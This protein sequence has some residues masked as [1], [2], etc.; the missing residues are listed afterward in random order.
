MS[1]DRRL[2]KILRMLSHDQISKETAGA[3][4]DALWTGRRHQRHDRIQDRSIARLA[5]FIPHLG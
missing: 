3:R 2:L 5:P 4:V 1:R